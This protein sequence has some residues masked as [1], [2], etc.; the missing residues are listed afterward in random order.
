[1][2]FLTYYYITVK[3]VCFELKDFLANVFVC[4]TIIVFLF[5]LYITY[6]MFHPLLLRSTLIS[7]I[8]LLHLLLNSV[9]LLPLHLVGRGLVTPPYTRPQ[10][11]KRT[12]LFLQDP[13]KKIPRC[14]QITT[15]VGNYVVQGGL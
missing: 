15:K 2:N 6:G 9:S 14:G 10:V 1:M 8:P 7:L 4:L 12:F 13:C 3:I 5:L 11:L